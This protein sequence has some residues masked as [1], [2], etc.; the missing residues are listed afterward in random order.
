MVQDFDLLHE[1]IVYVCCN[2][3][4]L[5]LEYSFFGISRLCVPYICER[6]LKFDTLL[7]YIPSGFMHSKMIGSP[8]HLSACY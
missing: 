3:Q 2:L 8:F 4:F 6:A 1:M 5:F 7:G